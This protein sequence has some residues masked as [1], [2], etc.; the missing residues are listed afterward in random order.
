MDRVPYV[1]VEEYDGG[2][3]LTYHCEKVGLGWY[4]NLLRDIIFPIMFMK[5]G[6]QL[7]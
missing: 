1:C 5:Y 3:F 2:P 7:P 6:T 4:Q